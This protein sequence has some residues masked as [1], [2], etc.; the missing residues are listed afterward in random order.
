MRSSPSWWHPAPSVP[1][2]SSQR[3]RTPCP[4]DLDRLRPRAPP[5]PRLPRRL[6]RRRARGAGHRRGQP[7]G[8]PRGPRPYRRWPLLPRGGGS[9]SSSSDPPEEFQA[10]PGIPG[11]TPSAWTGTVPGA[12][13]VAQAQEAEAIVPRA[14]T[15]TSAIPRTVAHPTT[16]STWTGTTAASAR[17]TRRRAPTTPS[18]GRAARRGPCTTP[19]TSSIRWRRYV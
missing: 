7:R 18:T 4:P 11:G 9:S 2:S 3:Q 8:Q 12:V 6:R 14:P 5:P 16:S 1:A 15:T 13:A 17:V 10:A 19:T